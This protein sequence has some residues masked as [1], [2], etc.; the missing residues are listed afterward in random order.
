MQVDSCSVEGPPK[1]RRRTFT[2]ARAHVSAL[3]F[4]H[5]ASRPVFS[6][7]QRSQV[8]FAR[9]NS[10][11]LPVHYEHPLVLNQDGLGVELTVNNG[12]WLDQQRRKPLIGPAQYGQPGKTPV[13]RAREFKSPLR[14]TAIIFGAVVSQERQRWVV[15]A[16]SVLG[17]KLSDPAS[18]LAQR[19]GLARRA[20]PDNVARSDASMHALEEQRNVAAVP[21]TIVALPCLIFHKYASC[22]TIRQ[23]AGDNH[24]RKGAHEWRESSSED[25]HWTPFVPIAVEGSREPECQ[26]RRIRQQRGRGFQDFAFTISVSHGSTGARFSKFSNHWFTSAKDSQAQGARSCTSAM[27]GQIMRLAKRA[28]SAVSN[29]KFN[30]GIGGR[31][32]PA[33]DVSSWY[34]SKTQDRS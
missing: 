27:A 2:P 29:R 4:L 22:V 32:K 19:A 28:Y 13:Q 20:L 31:H 3:T 8:D 34:T 9:G 21:E 17:V 1:A 10:S 30:V 12:L 26:S 24:V 23:S 15:D 11:R 6:F 7:G 18:R 14:P 16:L 5:D 33:R 25:F